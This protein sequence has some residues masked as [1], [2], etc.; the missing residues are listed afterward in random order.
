M[1]RILEFFEQLDEMVYAADMETH[2]LVYM[3][4]HL[5]ESLGYQTHEEYVGKKCY[6]VLQG[7]D[8]PCVFCT[9]HALEMGKFISWVH[10]NPVLGKRY[11]IKDSVFQ[12]E[13]RRYRVE[14]AIDVDSHISSTAPYYYARTET[15]L[16]ECL[17]RVLG[18]M[19]PV[20]A[21]ERVL[22]Y[23]GETFR[24]DR[25]YVFEIEEGGELVDNTYEWCRKG[26]SPQ[27]DLLQK[28]AVSSIGWW[29]PI[30]E[31][32]QVLVIEDLEA[33]KEKEPVTYAILKPQNISSL[34]AG[35]IR[36]GGHVVGF[37]GADNPDPHMV[38]MLTPL[39]NVVGYF[40]ATLLRRRDLLHRLNLLSFRDPLTE[41]FN[42]NAMFE[43]SKQRQNAR[44]V[45]VIYCDIT[46]LKQT[47]DALGHSA[48]DQLIQ[49]CYALLRETLPTRWIYRTGGDEFVA[50]FWDGTEE[51]FQGYLRSL[52]SR[53]QQDEHH[54]AV[55][56]A[57]SEEGQVN[58][59]TLISRADKV[60]YQDKRDYYTANYMV[61]GVDR[62]RSARLIQQEPQK[63]CSLFQE[64]L[65]QINF[66]AES[67][68]RS[69]SQDNSSSYFYFGDMQKDLFYISDNMRED[70]GFQSNI[71]SGLF[72]VWA[73]RITT[74]EFRDLYWQDVSGM[75]REGR[76][77]HDLRYQVRDV[78]GHNQWIRC[79]GLLK[80]SEDGSKPLFFSGRIAH[81]DKDFVI[82]PI[83]NLPREHTAFMQLHELVEKGEE[84]LIIGFSLN[85][86]SEINSTKGRAYADHLLR[87][88]ADTLVE[89][90]SW[91][92]T[93]YRL[94]GMRCMAVVNPL[95]CAEGREELVGQIRDIVRECY[96]GMGISV[97]SICSFGLMEYPYHN[98]APEDLVETLISLIR[99]AKQEAVPNYVDY[100]VQ[101][102]ARVKEMSNMALALSQ[103]VLHGMQH[104][105]IVVQPVVSAKDGNAI[106]GEVLLRWTFQGKMI[107]PAIFIPILEQENMIHLVGRW[108]FEQAVCTC[109]RIHAHNPAFYLTF[110]VS[111]HQL[112]DDYFLDFMR[113]TLEKYHLNGSNLVAELTESCLDEEPEKLQFFVSECQK[114]GMRIALDDFGSG[115]SSLRMLLQYPSSIIKLDRSLVRE[116]TESDEKM[117]FIRSIVY[118]CHQFGKTVCME[119]VES[120]DQNSIIRDT[121]CDMIQGYYYYRPMEVE[122]VYRLISNRP[123]RE[124]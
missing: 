120:S 124:A 16:N 56:Y 75:L 105:R 25:V 68:F 116:V 111:L 104:F 76:C 8:I 95:C 115:Y 38:G 27:K 35:P 73:Q 19:D 119:G 82:D 86:I 47:N 53:I 94:E 48:G 13:G 114:M 78:H 109:V 42:R 54:M 20:H 3:N 80:W 70:F 89:R 50:L 117:N 2:E 10:K 37:L 112:S 100:S 57:W 59:E 58:L 71:V 44:S 36:V 14:M 43:H 121:G 81:Q 65:K 28:L 60:M 34:A 32:N 84:T 92:M 113:E 52:H 49:H 39:L 63:T 22:S 7:S 98:F 110:N 9:N 108:V 77:V 91:K 62:R 102:I 46:G 11:L 79:Y 83:T 85:S 31:E 41:A 106:G 30:F 97:Q 118:A 107:S 29:M 96:E 90:L 88:I 66:D 17:Q 61:P 87:R 26:V 99:V 21:L 23:L 45:G 55:G 51:E 6:E 40:I 4:R 67:L 18:S 122:D 33:L 72:S 69:F 12:H 123:E 1:D 101:N 93:F 5:R 64:F 103:D 24:C 15:I 74:P